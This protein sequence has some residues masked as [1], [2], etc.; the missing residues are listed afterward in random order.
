M[1]LEP[2][3][4]GMSSHRPSWTWFFSKTGLAINDTTFHVQSDQPECLQ[5][6]QPINESNYEQP[7]KEATS[8]VEEESAHK[9]RYTSTRVRRAPGW[10]KD[11]VV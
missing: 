7:M 6:G 8:Q 3:V 11:Y 1:P 10:F 4:E 5:E 9:E 2:V